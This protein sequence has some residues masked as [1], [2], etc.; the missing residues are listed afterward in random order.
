MPLVA[1]SG[2]KLQKN[3]F[4]EVVLISLLFFRLIQ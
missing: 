2:K 3:T 4:A 1:D